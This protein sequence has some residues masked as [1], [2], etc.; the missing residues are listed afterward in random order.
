MLFEDKFMDTYD[1]GVRLGDVEFKSLSLEGSSSLLSN[2]TKEETREAVWQCEGS[3]SPDS[4]EF[5]FNFIKNSWDV[6]KCDVVAAVHHLYETS[7]I[8]KGCNASFIAVVPKV[9]DPTKLD[10]YRPISLVGSLY[11]I[12]SKV[13]SDRSQ[14]TFLKDR[15]M[16]D[17][18]PM[19]MR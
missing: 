1:Y 6:L 14:S 7:N 5:N 4:D 13:L 17:S 3:K 2:I 12:I 16:L 19:L 8:P 9:H 15:G 11:K 10:Q 18:V